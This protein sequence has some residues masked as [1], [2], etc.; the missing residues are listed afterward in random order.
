MS[1][2]MDQHAKSK[3]QTSLVS[4]HQQIVTKQSNVT[5]DQTKTRIKVLK[6]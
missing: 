1:N 2:K 6:T 4:G 3:K 5:V